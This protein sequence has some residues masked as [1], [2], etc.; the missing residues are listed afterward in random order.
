MSYFRIVLYRLESFQ[1]V[2]NRLCQAD[3]LFLEKPGCE[4]C[5]RSWG[6]W[7]SE[8]FIHFTYI[9]YRHVFCSCVSQSWDLLQKKWL[10][11]VLETVDE[12][13]DEVTMDEK[14]M[15]DAKW[16]VG[17]CCGLMC[18]SMCVSCACFCCQAFASTLGVGNLSCGTR[19]CEI[20]RWTMIWR[21]APE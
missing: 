16:V 18:V 8:A 14:R 12:D 3:G 7:R 2:L 15:M 1:I 19:K 9:T 11:V 17:N 21:N 4:E 6:E 13:L 10:P 20:N 5:R